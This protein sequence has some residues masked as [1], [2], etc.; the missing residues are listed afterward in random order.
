VDEGA[1]RASVPEVR[2]PPEH[3]SVL[4][5]REALRAQEE[6]EKSFRKTL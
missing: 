3:L 6:P 5:L 4:E 1:H 2:L